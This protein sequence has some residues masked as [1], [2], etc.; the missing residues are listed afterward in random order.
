MHRW[1]SA[2]Q[3]VRVKRGADVGTDHHLVIGKIKIRLARLVKKKLTEG[4][5]R[6]TFAIKLQNKFEYLYI[7]EG[8]EQASEKSRA[9][10]SSTSRDKI[11]AQWSKIENAFLGTC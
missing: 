6:D 5:L 1:K 10:Q 4:D 3:D 2:L 9:D 8:N 7:E 11:E